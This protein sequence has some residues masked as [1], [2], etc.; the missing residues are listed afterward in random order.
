[1]S[2]S[3]TLAAEDHQLIG[4]S[5]SALEEQGSTTEAD[6]DSFE[7][8]VVYISPPNCSGGRDYPSDRRTDGS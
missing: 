6:V 7:P 8:F 2:P 5:L 4:T 3:T 1:M